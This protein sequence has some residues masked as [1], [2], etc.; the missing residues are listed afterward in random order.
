MTEIYI[1]SDHLIVSAAAFFEA[2]AVIEVLSALGV[3][4][5]FLEVGIGAIRSAQ[6]ATALKSVVTNR[7]VLFLGSCGTSNAFSS[8]H[9]VTA[10]SAAWKPGDVRQGRGYL[11]SDTHPLIQT[12]PIASIDLMAQVEISCAASITLVVEE[13]PN[14]FENLEFYSVASS[15]HEITGRITSIFGVTNHLGPTAHAEWKSHF[16]KV[17]QDSAD[18][19]SKHARDCVFL[20]DS[21][22]TSP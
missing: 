17:A 6:I 12:T 18:F 13:K 14:V 16:R 1:P 21:H 15:W 19:I 20:R 11:I 9:L 3:R 4:T 22:H 5:T 2:S 8:P 10:S 7:E